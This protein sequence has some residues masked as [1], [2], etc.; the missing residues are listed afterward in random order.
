[1]NLDDSKLP[2][3][4]IRYCVFFFLLLVQ[5]PGGAQNMADYNQ[6]WTGSIESL[7]SF[8]LKLE[9]VL[10]SKKQLFKISNGKEILSYSFK[11]NKNPFFKFHFTESQFFEGELS[12]DGKQINGF[13]KSGV[14]FYHV[15]LTKTKD[16]TYEGNWNFL[17]VEKLKSLTFYMSIENGSNNDFEA[18]PFFR[19][20]RFTGTWCGNFK[21]EKDKLYFGDYKTGLQ[22][23]AKLF[24]DEIQLD[25]CIGEIPFTSLKLK[26]S[27]NEWIIGDLAAADRPTSNNLELERMENAVLN[28]ELPNTHSVLVS[29]NG[30]LIYEKNFDAFT[31]SIPQDLRS[32]SKSISSAVMGIAIDQSIIDNV[33][34]PLFNYLPTDYQ[35]YKEGLKAKIDI[36]SLL[37]MSSGLDADDYAANGKSQASEGQYQNSEDWLITVLEASMI[38]PPNSKANYGSANPFLLGLILDS[39]LSEPLE[40]FMDK[41]LFQKLGIDNYIIQSDINGKPYF[42][43]GMY[44]CASD[45]MKFGELFLKNGRYGNETIISQ[46]WIKNSFNDYRKLENVPEQNGYGYLWWHHAYKINGKLIESIEARG[47][48]GQ[49][50]FV[51]PELDVVVAITSGNFRSGKTQQPEFILEKYILPAILK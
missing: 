26:K 32:A 48:G 22:F 27:E 8:N 43:G 45:M 10:G 40:M 4:K 28:D 11:K 23:Q 46:Q 20:N 24:R 17:I 6:Q 19:D 49:Y 3:M 21:K 51:V 42:G 38:N 31:S 14:L 34:Q 50:I 39:A 18:Y 9:I 2:P 44:M 16:N 5:I 47:N 29:K 37:T 15:K 25:F 36:K 35:K 1:M 41:M 30:K 7:T 13:I 12:N 33:E